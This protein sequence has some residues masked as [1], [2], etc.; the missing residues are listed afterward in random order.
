MSDKNNVLPNNLDAEQALLGC[1]LIDNQILSDVL[2]KL[3][4]DDF[5]QES[6]RFIL[7]A[8]K[9]VYLEHKPLDLVTLADRL[10][11]EGNLEKSGGLT[12]LTELTQVTPSSANYNHYFD[13]IRRDSV[14]RKLIRASRDIIKYAQSSDDNLKSVQYAEELVYDISKTNDSSSVKDIRE[15]DGIDLVLQKFQK[16]SDDKDAFRGVQTGLIKLDRLTNGL[17]KS[18]L[19]VLAARPGM[20][21]T[22]L[23][24]N[25]V[26]NAALNNDKVCAVFSL[27]MPEVQIIQRLM[28]GFAGVSMSSALS[29]K[30]ESN[31]WKKLTKASE[32]M[33][34]SRIYIDDSSRVT[35]AEILSK[36]RRIK[37]KNNGQLD[38]IMIDYIQ[39]MSS[40]KKNAE[41]NRTQEVADITRELKIMAKELDVPVIALSQLRRMQSKE[42][43]LSDLRESGAI[44]QDAD[45]VMFINRPDV[46]ATDEELKKGNII[47]GM[48]DLIVA[49]HRNGGLDRI[50]LRFKG[51]LTKFVNPEPGDGIEEP[52]YDNAP[53]PEYAPPAE[54][55]DGSVVFSDDDNPPF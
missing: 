35:P 19:I 32:K 33:R 31:D 44:E 49:K 20:G 36:C 9:L 29:G 14:N 8:M 13:I 50:K 4:E 22:S 48:A 1:M 45:I 5:Y 41:Q 18:D 7:S 53:P 15:S 21:K 24:M 47:K 52:V 17:Q 42:P 26:E 40:G 12:Y 11:I 51:E 34:K 46:G 55:T 54:E 27:E 2:E 10:E 37:S 38:L 39:L 23:A 3:A 25:I 30:L 16:L 28:C 43:Q 6:H